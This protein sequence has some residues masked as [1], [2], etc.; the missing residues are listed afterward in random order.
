MRRTFTIIIFSTLLLI[1]LFQLTTYAAVTI[2]KDYYPDGL[3]TVSGNR[4]TGTDETETDINKARTKFFFRIIQSILAI[5]GT[6]ALF[7]IINN[8]WWMIASGGSE[9]KI[10]EHK[11]G[12]MWAIVGLILIILSYSIIQFI[13]SI[14]FQADEGP[15]GQKTDTETTPSSAPGDFP[16]P[17]STDRPA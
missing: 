5:A 12:L 8:A 17:S 7:F 9:E 16:E 13:I 1:S 10:T 3:P 15:P 4:P 14:G 11:K 6:V 2:P